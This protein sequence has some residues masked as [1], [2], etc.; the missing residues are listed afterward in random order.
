MRSAMLLVIFAALAVADEPPGYYDSVDASNQAALRATLHAVID[1][2]VRLPYTSSG[3]DTWDVLELAQRNPNV[4]GEIIDV[5]RNESFTAHG[6]GNNDYQREH[7]WPSSY[8]FPNDGPDNYPF[9]DCHQLWLCDGSYNQARSNKPFRMCNPGC[10]EYVTLVNNGQGGGSGNYPGNSNWTTGSFSTGTW[11]VWYGKRGD[12]ARSLLYLDVRYAGGTHGSTGV[13]EPDL[14]LTNNQ[15]LI[16]ASSTGQNE[17]IAYMG[18]LDV[19]LQWHIDDPVDDDERWRNDIVHA[20]QGNRNPFV[21][22][23]E[24]VACLFSGNCG[25]GENYCD[26][27]APN[28][29]GLPAVISAAGSNVVADD[30]FLLVCEQ[31]PFNQFGYFLASQTQD[32]VPNPGGSQGNLCLGGSVARFSSQVQSSSVFGSIGITVDLGAIPTSPPSAVQAGETWSFSTWYRDVNPSA[33]SNFSDGF[34]V[35]FQ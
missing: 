7:T 22:H 33:T 26:P 31:M 16:S 30:N 24:W 14:I 9:T 21:D 11:E 3:T 25:L 23:P 5:Y 18:M 34:E 17:P 15:S 13:A 4:N 12:V 27:A 20:F 35:L 32:F 10:S 8:G 19:L 29:T 6:T 1:D 28:S 2:H